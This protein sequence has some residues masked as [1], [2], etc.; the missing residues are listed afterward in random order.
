MFP[1]LLPKANA[2]AAQLAVPISVITASVLSSGRPALTIFSVA[3]SR[4]ANEEPSDQMKM[5]LI[6]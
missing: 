3:N 4:A 5:P 2:T 1:M 6:G